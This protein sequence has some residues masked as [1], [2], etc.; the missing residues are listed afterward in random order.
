MESELQFSW[1]GGSE[2]L[3]SEQPTESSRP[4]ARRKRNQGPKPYEPVEATSTATD[5]ADLRQDL[6]L[7]RAAIAKLDADRK[8]ARIRI[9]ELE[10]TRDTLQTRLTAQRRRVLVLERQLEDAEVMPA[11]EATNAG[12]LERLFGGLTSATTV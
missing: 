1:P 11:P 2:A 5:E 6:E 9:E 10:Q 8:A 3:A 7:A 12:W 4:L